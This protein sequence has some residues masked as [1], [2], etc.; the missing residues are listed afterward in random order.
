MPA[1]MISAETG[2]STNVAGNSIE[3]V[4]I[5][6]M[7]GS[8]PMSVPRSTP[9]KQYMMFCQCSATP[10]PMTRLFRIS[11]CPSLASAHAELLKRLDVRAQRDRKLQ[12]EDE[13]EGAE[14]DQADREDDHGPQPEV[15]AAEARADDQQDARG[16]H[17]DDLEQQAERHDRG[18]H[19]E[20]RL[21]V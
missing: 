15:G 5:G 8:T 12:S 9:T 13:D 2:G 6:P 18:E 7:P 14:D 17:A 20:D 4:A 3:I 10:K 21:P 11:M 16:E 1:S 19:P